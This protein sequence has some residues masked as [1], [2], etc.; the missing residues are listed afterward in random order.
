M[1]RTI[2][3]YVLSWV[4]YIIRIFLALTRVSAM[5]WGE[6]WMHAVMS[7]ADAPWKPLLIV[8]ALGV[9]SSPVLPAMIPVYVLV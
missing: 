5:C 8:R 6:T 3:L 2:R 7:L 4:V 9:R 1:G